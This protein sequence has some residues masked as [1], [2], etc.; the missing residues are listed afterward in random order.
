MNALKLFVNVYLDIDDYTG[1]E[2]MMK[3]LFRNVEEKLSDTEIS[4]EDGPDTVVETANE[5]SNPWR[6]L[7]LAADTVRG[8]E[9]LAAAAQQDGALSN[10]E[11]DGLILL[12]KAAEEAVKSQE[13]PVP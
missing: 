1:D 8:A 11:R 12:A 10:I 7:L 9:N 3:T 2:F 6:T 4:D 5:E 13:A